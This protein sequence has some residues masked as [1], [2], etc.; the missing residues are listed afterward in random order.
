[1][2][3]THL[4]RNGRWGGSVARIGHLMSGP[5]GVYEQAGGEASL[6][7]GLLTGPHF[8]L[9]QTVPGALRL[10]QNGEVGV[11]PDRGPLRLASA[12]ESS[13]K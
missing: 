8:S 4:W 2:K 5:V 7:S 13:V 9:P 11:S 10:L 12:R 1:M 3:E 6:P